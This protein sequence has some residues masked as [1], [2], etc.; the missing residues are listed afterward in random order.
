[1]NADGTSVTSLGRHPGIIGLARWLPDGRIVFIAHR[2]DGGP[3][4]GT[5]RASTGEEE[6]FW[7]DAS[8]ADWHPSGNY[9]VV[10][11]LKPRPMHA[12]LHEIDLSTKQDR[13][14]TFGEEVDNRPRYSPD[15]EWIVFN[16]GRNKAGGRRIWLIRR[17]GTN[18]H[19]VPLPDGPNT[20]ESDTDF[21][22]DGQ[23]L[24]FARGEYGAT[25]LYVCRVDGTDL[26]RITYFD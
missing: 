9:V 7:C 3:M 15:G 2:G 10:S 16:T 21:S 14:F 4:L 26:R 5:F 13:R 8:Y 23:Y 24:A 11:R 25:D 20:E 12:N 19:P 18:L 22:P 1:M 17:D 6:R